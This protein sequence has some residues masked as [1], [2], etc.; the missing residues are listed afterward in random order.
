MESRINKICR[1]LS[2]DWTWTWGYEPFQQ[3]GSDVFLTVSAGGSIVWV[4]SAEVI[5]QVVNRRNDFPKAL[6][7]YKTLNIY[8]VNVL[9]TEG[10]LWRQHRKITSPSFTEKNNGVVWKESLDQATAMMQSYFST[11][12]ISSPTITA[13]PS[14]TARLTLHIISKAGFG[15]SLAWPNSAAQ[16]AKDNDVKVTSADIPKGHTMSYAS[17]LEEL[18]H[19]ILFMIIIPRWVLSMSMLLRCT[20][21]D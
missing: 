13:L 20:V 17:A 15:V 9:T 11:S 21:L 7:H 6:T 1:F 5:T 12:P 2:P 10:A 4:A 8:G 16:E 18:L 3:I 14:D 19:H